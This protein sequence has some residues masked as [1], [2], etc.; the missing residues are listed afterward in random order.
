MY[1]LDQLFAMSDE[2]FAKLVDS[3]GNI[4]QSIINDLMNACDISRVDRDAAFG[5]D[6]HDDIGLSGYLLNYCGDTNDDDYKEGTTEVLLKYLFGDT[7]NYKIQSPSF[8]L[9]RYDGWISNWNPYIWISIPDYDIC[10]YKRNE[11]DE[12]FIN[13]DLTDEK[14]IEAYFNLYQNEEKPSPKASIMCVSRH[15]V[16]DSQEEIKCCDGSDVIRSI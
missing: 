3:H 9:N 11:N 2:E 15:I 4:G 12:W 5:F 8:D 1:T 14:I 6:T 10:R 13:E 16:Q 7:V